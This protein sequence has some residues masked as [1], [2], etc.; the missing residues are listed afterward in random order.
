ML[1][2]DAPAVPCTLGGCNVCPAMLEPCILPGTRSMLGGSAT[3]PAPLWSPPG[4]YAPRLPWGEGS[5]GS[6]PAPCSPAPA[7]SPCVT[8]PDHHRVILPLQPVCRPSM[9]QPCSQQ[10]RGQMPALHPAGR[11][12]C[13]QS[14]P[15][16]GCHHPAV[17]SHSCPGPG[18]LD[19]A[20]TAELFPGLPGTG[21]RWGGGQGTGHLGTGPDTA[22]QGLRGGWAGQGHAPSAAPQALPAARC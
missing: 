2:A 8:C 12:A 6:P 5:W 14:C 11:A 17:P 4:H 9:G 13:A 3:C 1:K 15:E 7:P 21:R 16:P 10:P 18:S 19:F 22:S 20:F